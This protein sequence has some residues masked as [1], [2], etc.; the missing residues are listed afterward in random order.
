MEEYHVIGYDGGVGL[1]KGLEIILDEGLHHLHETSL[2]PLQLSHDHPGEGGT[3]LQPSTSSHCTVKP[4]ESFLL[5]SLLLAPPALPPRLARR[6]HGRPSQLGSL[7]MTGSIHK[8]VQC[9]MNNG[10]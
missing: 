3:L 4:P 8:F 10:V 5:S 1:L 6:F 7:I 2:L 9:L